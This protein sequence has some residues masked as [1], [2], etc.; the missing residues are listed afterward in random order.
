MTLSTDSSPIKTGL[1]A[2]GMSGKVFHAPFLTQQ[3]GL[4]HNA[5]VTVRRVAR[6]MRKHRISYRQPSPKQLLN[7]S[8][9][10]LLDVYPL[11]NSP[12]GNHT[13]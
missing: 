6:E 3:I 4:P 11:S 12:Q 10:P 1:L 13:K 9:V 8:A 2:Y 7:A 5:N